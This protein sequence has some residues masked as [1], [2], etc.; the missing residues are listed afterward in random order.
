MMSASIKELAVDE[1]TEESL[2]SNWL[3][4]SRPGGPPMFRGFSFV[5]FSDEE[6]EEK[7]AD[8]VNEARPTPD[9]PRNKPRPAAE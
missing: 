5:E 6:D 4:P 9:R 1:S 3:P 8:T 7:P 2:P